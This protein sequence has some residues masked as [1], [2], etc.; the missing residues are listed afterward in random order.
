MLE[1]HAMTLNDASRGFCFEYRIGIEGEAAAAAARYR[2]RSDLVKLRDAMECLE[3]LHEASEISS[4]VDFEFHLLVAK[5][6][7]NAF[8][9]SSLATLRA[10]ISEGML[11]AI[12][13][14]ALHRKAKNAAIRE[15]HKAVFDAIVDQDESRAREAMRTHLSRCRRSTQHWDEYPPAPLRSLS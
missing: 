3:E 6:T 10:T 9:V 11:L 4:E 13:P 5:A 1:E 14:T 12:A 2:Q 8:F 15:Q 7:K